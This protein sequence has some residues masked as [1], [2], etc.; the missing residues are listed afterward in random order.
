MKRI[1][2]RL[3]VVGIGTLA[4]WLSA[5]QPETIEDVNTDLD[6]HTPY[7]EDTWLLNR[8]VQQDLQAPPGGLEELDLTSALP[9][10]EQTSITMA[11]DTYVATGVLADII[12][13]AGSWQLD[14]NNF[15]TSV[16]FVTSD[17]RSITMPLG[18]PV[19]SYSESMELRVESNDCSTG[20]PVVAYS[21][22]FTR[23]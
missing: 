20:E 2:N 7:F 4:L 12:G 13:E 10:S 19:Q 3:L 6:D 17:N 5:C 8:F 16:Q 23:S 9:T 11:G 15:A 21:Y 22:N 18:A 14:D 1:I